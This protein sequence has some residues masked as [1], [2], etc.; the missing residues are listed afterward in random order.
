M[1][2]EPTTF[3]TIDSVNVFAIQQQLLHLWDMGNIVMLTS[4]LFTM[5]TI[6]SAASQRQRSFT[7]L[8]TK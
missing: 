4:E 5:E 1:C 2:L 3:L 7:P 8:K 6:P